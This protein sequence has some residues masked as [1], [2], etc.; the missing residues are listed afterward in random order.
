MEAHR[1]PRGSSAI[2]SRS[3]RA[4]NQ[5]GEANH[6]PAGFERTHFFVFALIALSEIDNPLANNHRQRD[7]ICR[8]ILV[9]K[10]KLNGVCVCY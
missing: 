4:V 8:V 6:A 2:E 9:I 3:L 5:S 7:S 1:S 10:E